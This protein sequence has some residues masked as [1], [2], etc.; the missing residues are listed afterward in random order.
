MSTLSKAAKKSRVAVLGASPKEGRYS[1]KAVR[2]LKKYGHLPIPIHP[3]GHTVDGTESVRSLG[4]IR[5]EVD[6]LTLYVRASISDK[7]TSSILNLNPRRVI[8]NPGSE[9]QK[10]A[11][12]LAE[13]SVIVVEDCTLVML[14]TDQF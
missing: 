9:N 13:N 4:D 11:Q 2:M 6:T 14:R 12:K 8:F 10:L 5:G 1:L 7:L 3:S